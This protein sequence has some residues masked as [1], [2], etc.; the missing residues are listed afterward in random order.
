MEQVKVA[1]VKPWYHSKVLW[2][3]LLAAGLIALESQF[4]MLQPYL[5]GSVY[6][7]VATALTVGN[8]VLRVVTAA[9]LAF[10]VKSDDAA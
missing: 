7:W 9:P 5:P 6:A 10:G 3:N 4:A 2:F 8:A 1:V